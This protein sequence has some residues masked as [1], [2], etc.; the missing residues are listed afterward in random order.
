MVIQHPQGWYT[1]D[2]NLGGDPLDCTRPLSVSDTIG[3]SDT[4]GHL[5]DTIGHLSDTSDTTGHYA[6]MV[7]NRTPPDTIGHSGHLPDTYRTLIGH[8]YRTLTGHLSDTTG[9]PDS[10]GSEHDP[11]L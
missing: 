3:H 6:Q 5:S 1:A 9:H 2:R 10:Q 4:T 11:Q 7:Q 8:L